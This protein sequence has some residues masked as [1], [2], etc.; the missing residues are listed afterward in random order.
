MS[1]HNVCVCEEIRKYL[2]ALLSGAMRTEV[3]IHV[4]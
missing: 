4:D 2:D 1:T 3:L